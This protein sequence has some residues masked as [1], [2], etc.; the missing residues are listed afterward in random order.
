MSKIKILADTAC[1]LDIEYAQ[2]YGIEIVPIYV[3]IEGTTYRDRYDIAPPEFYEMIA[4]PDIV[5][6]T[7]QVPPALL[8]KKFKELVD[9]DYE[10]IAIMFSSGLSGTYQSACIAAESVN[11]EKV[12]VIDSK[13]ASMGYGLIVLEAAKMANSG[14]TVEEITERVIYMRDRMEHIFAVGSLEMLKRGGRISTTQAAVGSLL[15]VKP[16][17]QFSDGCIIPYEKARGGKQTIKKMV[18][19][20]EERGYNIEDQIIGFD[21]ARNTKFMRELEEAVKEKFNIKQIEEAEIGAA[22]G[23]HAGPGT[24]SVFFLRKDKTPFDKR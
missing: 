6:V 20:M 16:I 2:K 13:A 9:E 12:H 5:P 21:H 11:P 22:I 1:D 23:S 24:I 15:G 7:A 4:K 19:T 8:M 18:E 10:V 3:T 14:A 17:L